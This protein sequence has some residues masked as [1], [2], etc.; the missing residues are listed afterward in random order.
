MDVNP[1]EAP[2]HCQAA[3]KRPPSHWKWICIGGL[4]LVV[5]TY[6][7]IVLDVPRPISPSVWW[8]W[9]GLADLGSVLIGALAF[10]IG[11][12]G[13]VASALNSTGKS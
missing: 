11:F 8:I 7:G 1:Y 3:V 10:V 2:Q 13:W 4:G 6:L 12:I 5:F 9:I